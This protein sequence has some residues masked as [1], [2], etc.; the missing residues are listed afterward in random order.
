MET[1]R[2]LERI[3]LWMM[4]YSV[5][6]WLYETI[7]CSV[8]A[9]KFIN[10]GFLNGPYCPIY[11]CGAVLNVLVLRGISN[12]PLLFLAGAL[13]DCS[14]E[15]LTSYAM[16]K[17]FHARW[18][19]YSNRRFHLNGRVC[20][21]GALVF[22]SFSV[23][24]VELFQPA[25]ER[26]TD[27]IPPAAMH[28]LCAVLFVLFVTDIVVTVVGFS[29]FDGKLRELAA[30]AQELERRFT[31]RIH[32]PTAGEALLEWFSKRM[33][34]QQRRMIRAFPHLRSVRCDE[35]FA[36]LRNYIAKERQ[37]LLEPRPP[38]GKKG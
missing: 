7:L 13:L 15:Y 31:E 8:R 12:L 5:A 16:E 19:D 6:G 17:L 20:A 27:A 29:G 1:L 25:V 3:F 23:A 38:R 14:L 4:I 37:R 24:V 11:G 18:W 30:A 33:N 28:V 2:L 9:K 32:D 22:G 10:R 21:L 34:A 36:A 26:L 35:A